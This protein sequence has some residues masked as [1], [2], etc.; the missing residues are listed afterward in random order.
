[1]G[2]LA[3]ERHLVGAAGERSVRPKLD[4]IGGPRGSGHE[5][6]GGYRDPAARE[7][8]AGDEGVGKGGGNRM[9]AGRVE[10]LEAL[11]HRGARAARLLRHPRRREAGL[12]EGAPQSAA[13]RPVLRVEGDGL[14]LRAIAEHPLAGLRDEAWSVFHS[15]FPMFSET[16]AGVSGPG[17]RGAGA[18]SVWCKVYPSRLHDRLAQ[19][20]PE[21]GFP[22]PLHHPTRSDSS[23]TLLPTP[24]ARDLTGPLPIRIA[25]ARAEAAHEVR[26]LRDGR[27]RRDRLLPSRR[28]SRLR[29]GV[30]DGQ[31]D[32]VLRLLRGAR[33]RRATDHP[34]SPR[35]RRV[36]L[37]HPDPARARRGHG[38]PE[39]PRPRARAPRDRDRQHRDAHHGPAPDADPRLR[40]VPAGAPGAPRRRGGGVRV[41]RGSPSGQDADARVQVHEPRAPDPPLRLR[42]R[43]AR[44]GTRRRVR[45][46]ARVRDP[47][48]RDRGRRGDG[49]RAPGRSA[50]GAGRPRRVPELRSRQRRP[51]RAGGVRRLPSASS[52]PSAPT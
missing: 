3:R 27:H 7:D 45:R 26:N 44:D 48:P 11:A 49:P 35:D 21:W 2:R 50:G 24:F 33:P 23:E 13:P 40:G 52:A 6:S 38:D 41:Q 51:P 20:G 32:A 43:P 31:P 1:M 29:L 37:R 22:F 42:V 18:P 25:P 15:G 5:L 46:R 36:H 17:S 4:R 30:G 10:D 12:L 19:T 9:A 8:H 14:R 39:P 47:A 16:K 28:G 34:P